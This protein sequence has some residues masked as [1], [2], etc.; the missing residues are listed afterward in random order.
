M[1]RRDPNSQ[2]LDGA[3]IRV[4]AQTI[5]QWRQ[6][7]SRDLKLGAAH[8]PVLVAKSKAPLKP[9]QKRRP[10]KAT[11]SSTSRRLPAKRRWACPTSCA[12]HEPP[13]ASKPSL[14]DRIWALHGIFGALD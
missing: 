13:W 11:H 4:A 10:A 7:R 9:A 6:A 12:L 8:V 3:A 14:W 5:P 2:G 1:T